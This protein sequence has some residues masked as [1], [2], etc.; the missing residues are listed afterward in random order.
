MFDLAAR[1]ETALGSVGGFEIS[2]DGKKM[3]VSQD[4][5]YG[6]VD[7]PKAP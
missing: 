6:I 3:L 4:G 1:K 5:K 2:T 7:L